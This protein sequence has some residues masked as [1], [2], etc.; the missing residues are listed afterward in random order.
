MAE[1]SKKRTI[2][3]FVGFHRIFKCFGNS[4]AG[5]FAWGMSSDLCMHHG[6]EYEDHNQVTQE[7]FM[8]WNPCGHWLKIK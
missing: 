3:E 2:L 8:F 7:W 1:D 5:P 6:G 4:G